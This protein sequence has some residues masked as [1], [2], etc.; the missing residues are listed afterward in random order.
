MTKIEIAKIAAFYDVPSI[1]YRLNQTKPQLI[2]S[3]LSFWRGMIDHAIIARVAGGPDPRE[4]EFRGKL[5]ALEQALGTTWERANQS[6]AIHG[7]MK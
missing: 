2:R 6:M 7:S 5:A 1:Y 4:Q 3:V